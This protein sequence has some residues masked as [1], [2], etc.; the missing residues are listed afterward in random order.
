MTTFLQQ[1]RKT[2]IPAM[3]K[4]FGIAN[5]MAV[6]KLEKIVINTGVG[7]LTKDQKTLDRIAGDIE[8]LSGQK[9]VFRMAKKSIASFKIREGV[10][11]GIS[12]TLRGARMA[13]FVNRFINIALPRSRDF[14]GI[15][16]RNID[17]FGNLNYGIKE[18]SIFPELNYENVKDIFGLQVTFV[19]TA[20][21]REQGAALFKHLGFPLRKSK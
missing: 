12:V 11:V 18:S 21:N 16:P 20:G 7:R 13:D 17:K 14:Q 3:Q 10:P 5:V 6:P 19:T 8:K 4:E 1:Y 2:I 9:P 15:D